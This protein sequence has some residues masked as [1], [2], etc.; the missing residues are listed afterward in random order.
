MVYSL[1][2]KLQQT[3]ILVLNIQYIGHA[4]SDDPLLWC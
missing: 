1:K 2:F 3:Q 4:I